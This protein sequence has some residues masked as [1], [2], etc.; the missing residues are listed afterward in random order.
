MQKLFHSLSGEL[1]LDTN[2]DVQFVSD[3]YNILCGVN[4]WNAQSSSRPTH[5]YA[6]FNDSMTDAS[7]SPAYHRMEMTVVIVCHLFKA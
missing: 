1:K 4:L 2:K 7:F 6:L 5:R 3:S